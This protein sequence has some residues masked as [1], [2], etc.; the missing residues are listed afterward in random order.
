[1]RDTYRTLVR[2]WGVRFIKLD[3]MDTTAIE[4]YHYRPNTTALEAQRIGLQVIR[5]TVGEEV[6]LDKDGSPMLNPVGLVDTG[7]ISADTGHS[8]ER[9]KNAASGIAARFYMQRN[10]FVNDPDAFNVTARHLMER[11]NERS[12]ISLIESTKA[13]Q[14]MAPSTDPAVPFWHVARPV[15]ADKGRYGQTLQRYRTEIRSRWTEK[16][17]YFLFIC[18]YEELN[19]KPSPSTST[20]TYQL[21]DWDV[22]EVFIGSDFQNLRRYREFEM[23]PLG[24]WVD[25]D[26]DLAKPHHEDGW[27]W[28]S[29]FVVAARIDS[30][31]KI[32]YGAMR[33]PFS[34][35]QGRPPAVGEKFRINLFRSQG[36]TP[37]RA[38]VVW[39][40]TMSDTFHIPEKFG[41][42]R[43]I[44]ATAK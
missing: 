2:E 31:A 14:D 12:S 37:N 1:M 20:E 5:N 8:F 39:Q 30:A 24:E 29:G 9:T 35:L 34:A 26:I 13:S 28:N 16:N 42:L 33:V 41:L 21:W 25:L 32:W 38:A 40:P 23:S 10:F 15:Y 3:F 18:P 6:I 27:T 43:L 44:Q 4:G 7:R 22:A 11:A 17:L 36:P 19:L